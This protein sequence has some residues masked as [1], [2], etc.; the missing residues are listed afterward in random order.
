MSDGT[1]NSK[2]VR[3]HVVNYNSD[4]AGNATTSRTGEVGGSSSKDEFHSGQGD[5]MAR[6]STSADTQ[7]QHNSGSSLEHHFTN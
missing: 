5:K 4:A 7:K 1:D 3:L 6:A 2:E